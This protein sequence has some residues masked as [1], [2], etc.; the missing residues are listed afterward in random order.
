MTENIESTLQKIYDLFSRLDERVKIIV[1]KNNDNEDKIEELRDELNESLMEFRKELL[2]VD[3]EE[4]FD[5]I[6][7]IEKTQYNFDNELTRFQNTHESKKKTWTNL[8]DFLSRIIW[9]IITAYLLYKLG[10]QPPI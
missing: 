1:E 4:I 9:T 8:F 5:R 2:E 6:K 10:L 7:L 3:G